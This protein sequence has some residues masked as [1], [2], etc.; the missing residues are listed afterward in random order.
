MLDGE[1][2]CLNAD[3]RP[4]FHRL[5]R[6][7]SAPDAQAAS[8]LAAGDPARLI[9]FDVLHLDGRAV[10]ALPY[11]RRRELLERTLPCDRTVLANP[12]AAWRELDA[13]LEVTRTHT[14][15]GVVAKHVD[16]PYEPGRR[17]GAWL[18]HKHRGR[19]PSLS[20]VGGLPHAAPADAMPSSSP[21]P[22]QTAASAPL[23]LPSSASLA[24]SATSSEPRST[25]AISRPAA[26]L[27]GSPAASGSTSTST[28]ERRDRSGTP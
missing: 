12:R 27:T 3:G 13:V 24:N 6:R 23:A 20:P 28:A 21:A 16:A 25:S 19:R 5:R 14:L 11:H 1:L 10:R 7:L 9:V 26:E 15:E 18:K 22:P 8:C 2:V 4:D 17:S